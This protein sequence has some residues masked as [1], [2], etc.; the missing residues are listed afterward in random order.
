MTAILQPAQGSAGSLITSVRAAV[1]RVDSD[2]PVK[3]ATIEQLLSGALAARRFVMG[4][5]L[6][7]ALIALA[8]ASVGVYGVVSY[9]VERRRREI[10]IRLALGTLAGA[11]LAFATTRVLAT[12]LYEVEPTDPATFAAVMVVLGAAGWLASFIPALRSTRID[13]IETMRA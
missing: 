8:L 3:F 6:T 10:G 9:A 12:M 1:Q 7:F 11:V 13:P 2:V 5:I 4:V